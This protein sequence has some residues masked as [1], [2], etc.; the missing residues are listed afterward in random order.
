[1]K[2]SE[3]KKAYKSQRNLGK[4]IQQNTNLL[5]YG[6][7]CVGA[8]TIA[9]QFYCERK[10]ELRVIHGEKESEELIIGREGHEGLVIGIEKSSHK[11]TWKRTYEGNLIWLVECIFFAMFN[12]T[13]FAF[14]PDRVL[15]EYP[16]VRLLV[17]YKFSK[18]T[19]PFKS[20]QVQLQAEGL[21]LKTLGFDTDSLY[22]LII[23]DPP[24]MKKDSDFLNSIPARVYNNI[25]S[26]ELGVPISFDSITCYL[27][28][29]NEKIAQLNLEWALEY[30]YSKRDAYKTENKNKCRSCDYQ[31]YCK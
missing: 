19:S 28:K 15:V 5:R 14:I 23:V 3:W 21:L 8:S 22:Y 9:D 7:K 20:R 4:T 16:K 18:Y 26:S 24:N 11:Q 12:N 29:F 1:M 31:E 6:K 30:W 10:V 2:K 17:E 27:F 13:Y 25:S